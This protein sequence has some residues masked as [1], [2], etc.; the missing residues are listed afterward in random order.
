MNERIKKLYMNASSEYQGASDVFIPPDF[1]EKFAKM[2]IEECVEIAREADSYNV[3]GAGIGYQ[4]ADDI[5]KNF[6][7]R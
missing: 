3:F 2:L 1:V 4:I 6:G 7:V 5:N